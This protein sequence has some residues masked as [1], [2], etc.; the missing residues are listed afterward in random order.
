MNRLVTSLAA[1]VLSTSFANAQ[2]GQSNCSVGTY[3]TGGLNSDGSAQGGLFIGQEEV[4]P[5]TID[6]TNAGNANAGNITISGAVSGSATGT[7]RAG[8]T[9]GRTSGVF[10]ECTGYCEELNLD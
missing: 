2:C 4:P 1:I 10:G 6:I 8:A 3:G 7:F 5:G 9:R